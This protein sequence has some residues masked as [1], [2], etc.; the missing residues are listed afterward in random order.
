[1]TLDEVA[2]LCNLTKSQVRTIEARALA[3]IRAGLEALYID[4]EDPELLLV[5][6]A[7]CQA[8]AAT[9]EPTEGQAPEP[10]QSAAQDPSSD[11][12]PLVRPRRRS[13]KPR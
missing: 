13:I 4:A 1:M 11:V 2:Q 3:K 7:L 6:R 9:G 5:L 10:G 8:S 12:D